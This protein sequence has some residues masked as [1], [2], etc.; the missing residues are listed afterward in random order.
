VIVGLG[1]ASGRRAGTTSAIVH[2]PPGARG[3]PPADRQSA[4]GRP[5]P[6]KPEHDRLASCGRLPGAAPGLKPDREAPGWAG[7][8]MRQARRSEKPIPHPAPAI[9]LY[10]NQKPWHHRSVA[11]RSA[12]GAAQ[13]NGGERSGK[14]LFCPRGRRNPLKRLAS[15]KE[16]QRNPSLFLGKIWPGLGLALLGFDKFGTGLESR[17]NT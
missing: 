14:R 10:E 7:L 13:A 17:Y 16:I 9:L 4:G 2:R 6:R 5:C 3:D 12:S 1:R 8:Q 15:D 11:D